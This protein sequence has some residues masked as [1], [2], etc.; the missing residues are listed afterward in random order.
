[1]TLDQ[2]NKVEEENH[3]TNYYNKK[4]QNIEIIK[5]QVSTFAGFIFNSGKNSEFL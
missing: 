2:T 1:M 3:T 5:S 4:K